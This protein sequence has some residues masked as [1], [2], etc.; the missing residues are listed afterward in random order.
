M[1]RG[2]GQKVLFDWLIP[3]YFK[4]NTLTNTTERTDNGFFLNICDSRSNLFF[5]TF[6]Y[7]DK[8]FA[9]CYSGYRLLGRI[10]IWRIKTKLLEP[11]T[12]SASRLSNFVN[13]LNRTQKNQLQTHHKDLWHTKII[14]VNL[15][16]FFHYT[17]YLHPVCS[18]FRRWK[19]QNP[20]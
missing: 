14:C 15:A 12:F 6:V 7:V 3:I 19:I 2:Q 20:W 18:T 8:L 1:S 4:F 17:L 10:K 16:D 9:I 5:N 11:T 13:H